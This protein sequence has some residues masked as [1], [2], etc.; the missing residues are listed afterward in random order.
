M[1]HE[2]NICEG[3]VGIY[4]GEFVKNRC[5]ECNGQLIRVKKH[6]QSGLKGTKKNTCQMSQSC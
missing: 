2:M 6:C 4:R 5:I 3:W 1:W